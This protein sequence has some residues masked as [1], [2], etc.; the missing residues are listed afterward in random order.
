MTGFLQALK[1]W[2]NKEFL[3][4]GNFYNCTKSQGDNFLTKIYQ[5]TAGCFFVVFF[6]GGGRLVCEIIIIIF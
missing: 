4:S 5:G 6:G 1:T 2:K 3:Q